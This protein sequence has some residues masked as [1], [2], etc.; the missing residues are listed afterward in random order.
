[1]TSF[2]DP[3]R[4]RQKT[5]AARR[6]TSSHLGCKTALFALVLLAIPWSAH[7]ELPLWL[8]HIV[9]SS[10]I[11]SA[12]YRA[13][14]LPSLKALYPR[15]PRES[16]T[17]L[18][19]RITATPDDAG[20]YQLR[21]R[22]DE[23]ALDE[24]AAEADWK[25]Y[26]TH[27]TDRSTGNLELADFY[28]RRLLIP[29]EIAVLRQVAAAPAASA[30]TYIDPTA[31]R[32]WQAFD[33][34][35]LLIQDQNLPASENVSAFNAFLARYP[36]QPAVYSGYLQFLL[37]Q[38][39]YPA[40]ETL[41][42]QY[43]RQFPQ[44]NI[45]PIRAEALL[46]ERRS[47]IDAA[48]AV[49]DNAFQP[50]WP[51][52]LIHAYFSLLDQTHRQ[53]A[54]VAAARDQL[55]QNP[56]APEALNALARIFFY[57]QQAGRIDAAQHTLDAFRIAREA[58]N[59]PW[60]ATDLYTL[61]T[62]T[63]ETHSYAESARYNFA[64]ASTNGNTPT[65]EPAAQAGLAGLVRILLEAPEQHLALGAQNLSLYRD[66]ATLDQGPGYWNGILSLWLNGTSPDAEYNSENAAAQSYFHRAKAAELL[67][68]LDKR[69]PSAAER[70]ALHAELIRALATYGEPGA[71]VAAGKQFLT[72]FP[73][74]PQRLD[75]TDLMAD[76]YARQNDT[77][78]EF[79]L[80]E[81]QLTQ[82]A[83]QSHGL[84]LTAAGVDTPTDTFTLFILHPPGLDDPASL[85]PAAPNPPADELTPKPAR[86]SLPAATAYT[87]VLDRYLGR[88]TA[89]GQLPRALAV[90][91]AQLDRNPNDPLLYE[92]LATFLQQNNLSAQQE[93]VYSLALAR[94]QEPTYYNKL[95]RLYLRESK[96]Q[97]FADLTHK[98]TDIFSGTELDAYFLNVKTSQPIGPQLALQLN[99]YA[100]KRFPH[101]L[102]FIE[103]LLSAYQAR[104]THDELAYEALIRAHWW[105][106]PHLT[107]DFLTFLS[108]TG[109]LQAE[110]AA[111][112]A[113]STLE[114]PTSPTVHAEQDSQN[115]AALREQAAIDIFTSHFEQ[116]A[117]LLSS[118]ADLYP[119]DADTTSTAVSLFRSLAY[120]DP[121]S[122]STQRAAALQTNLLQASPDSPEILATLGDLFAEATSTGGEDLS[123]AAPSWRRIPTLHPGSTQ[124]YLNAATIFWD[125][126]QFDDALAQIT[127]ARQHFRSPALFGFEAGAIE[128][129][130][131]S[132]AAAIREYTAAVLHPVD[133]AE[134][135][136]SARGVLN[137][138]FSPPSD[139]ADFNLQATAQSFV[140]DSQAYA[141]LLQLA[142][143]P[144]TSQ[145]V[146][147]ASAKA[148]TA[149]PTSSSALS[150]RA[151]ILSAQHHAPTLTPLLTQ[152]FDQALH[153]ADTLDRATAIGTIAQARN[154][155]DVYQR[156]LVKQAA[157]ALDPIQKIQLQYALAA[158]LE[159]HSETPAA[160]RIIDAVYTANPRLLGVVRATTDF[161][162]RPIF[163]GKPQPQRAMHTLLEAA[164]VATPALARDFTL[165]AA[166]RANDSGDTAQAR[167]LATTLLAQTPYDASVL[168]LIATSY[169]RAHDDAGL[170]QFF[171]AQ[172]EVARS[173]PNIP[174]D[175]RRQDIAL[176]RR[177]L[178]PA[179]SRLK[180]HDGVIA[181]YIAILS[182]YPEDAATAQQAALY[183]LQHAHQDQLLTFLRTT[184]QQSPRDSRFMVLLAQVETTFDDLPAAESAYSLAIA[185]R[186][187][188]PDLYT[189]RVDIE[190]RLS[191]SE[192]AQS[193]LAASDFERLYQL[194]YHNPTWMVRLA[195]LRARQQRP[196][197]AVKALQTAYITGHPR[198]AADYFSVAKQL[199]LWNLLLEARTYADQ[200]I[201][202]AGPDLLTQPETYADT[203]P[204]SGATTYAR[205]LTRLGQADTAIATLLAARHQ[206]EVSSTSPA[207]LAAELVRQNIGEDEARQFRENFAQQRMQ[208]ADAHLQAAIRAIGETVQTFYTPEQKQA[209]A[210][211]L[212]RLHDGPSAHPQLALQAA[213]AA[214]LTDRESLWRRQQL[215]AG[216][217]NAANPAAYSTLQQARLQFSELAHTL[218]SYAAR[219][220]PD[221]RTNLREQATQAYRDAGDIPSEL[222][223]ERS[224]VA[225]GDEGVRA[226]F[227]DLLLQHDRAALTELAA[228]TNAAVADAAVNVSVANATLPQALAAVQRRS[229]SL[230]PVWL[231]ASASLVD[232]YFAS[233]Q[234][235]STRSTD[236]TQSLNADATIADRLATQSDPL[237]HLT[238]DD[239]F[240]YASRFGI[241]LTTVPKAATLP[242]AEDFLAA[243][244][245][246]SP[247]SPAPYLDLAR[248]YAEASNLP[249]AVAEYNHALELAPTIPAS[250]AI[251]D[252]LAIL[253]FRANRKDDALTHWHAALDTLRQMQ[254]HAIYPE[255]W[256]N[257]L[258][259]ITRHL[260]ERHLTVAFR[261]DL[262][263][264]LGP[265]LAKNGTYRSNELL[266]SVYQASATP[267]D[268][269]D[270][271]LTLANAAPA[272]GFILSDLS[273]A[274]WLSDAS[275]QQILKRRIQLAL[276]PGSTDTDGASRLR[277]LLL[278]SYIKNH[279]YAEAQTF[280]TSAPV[281][282]QTSATFATAR[283]LLAAQAGSLDALLATFRAAPESAPPS[284]TLAK[285]ANQLSSQAPPDQLNA[286]SLREFV[287][288]QK[289]LDHTLLPTDF[290]ALA[291]S[292]VETND[293]PGAIAILRRL[294]LQPVDQ[295]AGASSQTAV[296][297]DAGPILPPNPYANTDA[298]ASLLE[299]A[300]HPADAIPFLTSLVHSVPWDASYR[301]RLAEAQLAA[302]QK[303]A[304]QPNLIAVA[305]NPL[306]PYD[307]RSQAARDLATYPATPALGSNELTFLTH[308][309]TPSNARQPY[310]A[311]ARIAAA[312]LPTTPTAD[313][314]VLLRE[315]IA[316]APSSSA[317]DHARLTLLL[318]QPSNTE[319]SATLALFRTIQNAPAP[320][321]PSVTDGDSDNST[322]VRADY[323]IS[324]NDLNLPSTSL[325]PIAASLD[326]PAQI[327][328]AAIVASAYERDGNLNTAFPYAQLAVTLASP[329]P[330][331][332][333][334]RHR[335]D[336]RTAILL[337]RRNAARRPIFHA[338][339]T[340]SIPVRP[341]LTPAG[342]AREEDQ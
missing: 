4:S 172:L 166:N 317:A 125:Y 100:A 238:G 65:H 140:G 105:E 43:Q 78:S 213:T 297:S 306:A 310:F 27:A 15:P 300:H 333:L 248:T 179:L 201:A 221:A 9:G 283:I 232:L 299:H 307:V 198:Q 121:T 222:R 301:L 328:L 281:T 159:A 315:A 262:E 111:L 341:R 63:A 103:N 57:D 41:I 52:Q 223:L 69:F 95:A 226:R 267:A 33:R 199:A 128:E 75:V 305:S 68:D 215:V 106:S 64:L 225:A 102:V 183:A 151:D 321:S 85:N 185:I 257:S 118:V 173:A 275:S 98:V 268:G 99:L 191:Q 119:S 34:L 66:I 331:A 219:L 26:A 253:L 220:Q 252:E 108:R 244:L 187:D 318:T 53:R 260:G 10:T 16:Q 209:F 324:P 28:Q 134:R 334:L 241:F 228:S 261:T 296:S 258:E 170:K 210:L 1:L 320:S 149:E 17:E 338:A 56:D 282:Q 340:P 117:P 239:F 337:E 309:T 214:A 141:R 146:D 256:F 329:A 259:T 47:N 81:T 139:A 144:S 265:Y 122:A 42:A 90:L 165:E 291:Q 279:Q 20:L 129:N 40:A 72:D 31:Q 276:A 112:G 61:A 152:L 205:I 131:H 231:P 46:A 91:R 216:S 62:L 246:Q 311:A 126:F 242:D 73:T 186:K 114:P 233:S 92:R 342:L 30:E 217:L 115:P 293:L 127:A 194:T 120:L 266:Q 236:F 319:P 147:E 168:N 339:L 330:Q 207:V 113:A 49:Y 264:I 274:A 22:A 80:Y 104:P 93:E 110:L 94:F 74:A 235:P 193:E 82:L 164:R 332:A 7:A 245:E 322:D 272:P 21:A 60:S 162:S 171:L 96:S 84:P 234:T 37:K 263:T 54:F 251:H 304:A 45:F 19:H 23:Q 5:E 87:R 101:D 35:L 271:L 137:A 18:A 150:L 158:S 182:A 250:P 24:A 79:A 175:L 86:T 316:I 107:D 176:L 89:T 133:H 243:Q 294:S 195:E 142:T 230:P 180:D 77:A 287:F 83:D 286:R 181:Q 278:Q 269:T 197:D 325:P 39:D 326:V 203:P 76:A 211:S 123:S 12:L 178:I 67:E 55:A 273:G 302:A 163:D 240:F 288:N 97:A 224:L 292:R 167:A 192:P 327:Q 25:L 202:I 289:Q 14:Q 237:H 190:L 303:D 154:L 174:P 36:N 189:A 116:A 71:V 135:I 200:A 229:Q 298:A 11:E 48:L 156:A 196:A 208:T 32:S 212:D 161:Y 88:L 3:N 143:R 29:Q 284:D 160:A 188:R 157:L 313:R 312:Q 177:G 136:D 109:K 280:L 138:W 132:M 290:L 6:P 58:R 249:A 254:Q 38:N 336:L 153:H 255:A 51:A 59:G 145:L 247:A 50:L 218:E 2:P 155:T 148:V 204:P 44:D 308:P 285:A 124:G 277:E 314:S 335:D 206:A 227:L 270:L 323:T 70:P 295:S 169:A 184:V 130:R 13:M 8:Q